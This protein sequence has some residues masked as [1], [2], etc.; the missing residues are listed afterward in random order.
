MSEFERAVELI[1]EGATAGSTESQTLEF[2]S[3][4]RSPKETLGI[5]ADAVVCFANAEGQQEMRQLPAT[6]NDARCSQQLSI[7]SV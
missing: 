7:S 5:L 3:E 6:E 2:K 4:A 1:L